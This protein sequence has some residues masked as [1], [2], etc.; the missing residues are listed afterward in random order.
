M[1]TK[2]KKEE[3]K[4]REKKTDPIIMGQLHSGLSIY[5]I[6]RHAPSKNDQRKRTE[7][8]EEKSKDEKKCSLR[9]ESSLDYFE[10]TITFESIIT[11]ITIIMIT[12]TILDP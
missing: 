7:E 1:N 10:P 11:I 3:R 8:S 12:R 5:G 4:K 2:G 6:T 9:I